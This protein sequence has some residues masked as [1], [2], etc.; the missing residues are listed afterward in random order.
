MKLQ[1]QVL[2][3]KAGFWNQGTVP[4]LPSCVTM[5]TLVYF[6]GPQIKIGPLSF[7][8]NGMGTG[9][10]S[11]HPSSWSYLPIAYSGAPGKE[12][13]VIAQAQL[14]CRALKPVTAAPS[15]HVCPHPSP[16]TFSS[17]GTGRR[18]EG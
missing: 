17:A 2:T 15:P 14:P 3:R 7:R 1:R 11:M 18:E 8:V 12:A 16:S 6:S 9:R 13:P 4:L 5:D 10:A